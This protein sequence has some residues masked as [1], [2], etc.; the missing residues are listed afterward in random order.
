MLFIT[1]DK[2]NWKF[3]LI[4]FILAFI[5]GGGI[6]AYQ[7]WWL[8]N[9]QIYFSSFIKTCAEEG[10]TIGAESMP[11]VCC[12]G[13][14]AVGGWPGGYTGDCSLLPPPTGLL[15]CSNWGNKV[16]EIDNGENK[17]NCPQDCVNTSTSTADWQT[18]A[19]PEANFTFKYPKD[20]EIREEYF[21]KQKEYLTVVIC[22][23]NEDAYYQGN[24]IRINEPQC[25]CET[26]WIQGN[27]ISICVEDSE[28]VG[29]YNQVIKSFKIPEAEITN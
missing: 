2:T 25:P 22:R 10:Q 23:K 1:K 26:K 6:L 8:P 11:S 16:C 15:I 9:E 21:Y 14:K 17:C 13:L 19:N 7:Y 28:I 29:I 5:A 12:K 4:V 24:C 27:W 18:Y 3:L 20:W